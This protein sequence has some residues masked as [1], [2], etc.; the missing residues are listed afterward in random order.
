[1]IDQ[2]IARRLRR[3]DEEEMEEGIVALEKDTA[4]E[5]DKSVPL[6]NLTAKIPVF[7]RYKGEILA[8]EA[9]LTLPPDMEVSG[10]KVIH[11]QN[12]DWTVG[13]SAK[14][15]V[16]PV[17]APAQPGMHGFNYWRVKDPLDDKEYAID[18]IWKDEGLA[19]RLFEH[20]TQ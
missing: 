16:Y 6:A 10:K 2:E 17:I 20:Y 18:K 11:F 15:I 5:T 8:T 14:A 12:N 3:P 13:G 9:M 7:L 1:M 19:D 4:N